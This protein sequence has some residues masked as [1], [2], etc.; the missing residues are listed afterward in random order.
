M[1]TTPH[2]GMTLVEQAQ[3]QK[4]VTVN[5]ALMRID[6]LL[7]SSAIAQ[8]LTAPPA[9]PQEGDVYIVAPSATG[10]W[11]GKDKHIAYF[12]QIW[13][14]IIP[15]EGMMLWVQDDEAFY[16]YSAGNWGLTGGGGGGG[17]INTGS[18][19][20]GDAGGV[21]KAKSAAT[22]VFNNIVAGS[23][24]SIS[25]GGSTGG[26]IVV[27]ATG[28]GGGVSELYALDDVSLVTPQNGQALVYDGSAWSNGTLGVSAGGTGRT[29]I[30][31]DC[32][33]RGNGTGA[34]Q[35]SG[36]LLDGNNAI[37][38]FKALVGKK[39]GAAYTLQAGDSG[40]VIECSHG[41]TIT[42]TLPNSL[43]AGF[44]VT[45]VQ[46]GTGAVN[47]STASGAT[48][49]N[50]SGHDSTA[51]QYAVCSLYVSANNGGAA[52]VYVMAGDSA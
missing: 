24:I 8:N 49:H 47:F 18:N 50:R 4:E 14:F 17:E 5:M 9:E 11:A 30:T 48:L 45:V 35:E 3:A 23:N 42:L 39:T 21:F 44:S 52:A 6:A 26:D 10:E 33:L 38:G 20:S 46:T 29:S 7:N 13:R 25:G 2:L 22:L 15:N 19:A 31:A 34:L 12:D 28:G 27:S 1:A 16:V 43:A 37:A 36:V 51:G 32:L 41:S 40:T